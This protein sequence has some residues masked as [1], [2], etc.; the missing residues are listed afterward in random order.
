[1]KPKIGA[2]EI[3]M[4]I[5]ADEKGLASCDPDRSGFGVEL[6]SKLKT[7]LWPDITSLVDHMR[8]I[9]QDIIGKKYQSITAE[10][11]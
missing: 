5:S 11:I 4:V 10:E 8:R 2:F 1:M 9:K 7:G 3:S 6:W